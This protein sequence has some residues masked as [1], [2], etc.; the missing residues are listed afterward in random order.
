MNVPKGHIAKLIVPEE[1][2][3]KLEA[4]LPTDADE[5]EIVDV[6]MVMPVAHGLPVFATL[7]KENCSVCGQSC[8]V[9]PVSEVTKRIC[10]DCLEEVWPEWNESIGPSLTAQFQEQQEEV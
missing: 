6:S 3:D 5:D 4:L 10:Y 8:W 1:I 9:S 2:L 7:R